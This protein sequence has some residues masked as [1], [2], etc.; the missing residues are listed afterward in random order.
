V[1]LDEGRIIERGSHQDLVQNGG[2]YA[3]L[4]RQ[5]QLTEEL[6]HLA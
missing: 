2:L 3:D 4:Y 6:E 1:V 5:Q